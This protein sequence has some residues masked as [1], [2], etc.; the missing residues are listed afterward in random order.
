VLDG[1]HR[2]SV[3]RAWMIDDW[4]DKA[5]EFYGKNENFEDI[6]QA[7]H[8]AR[9]AVNQSIGPFKAFEEAR[10]QFDEIA[11]AGGAPMQLMSPAKAQMARFYLDTFGSNRT[12]HAQW[13]DGDYAAAEESFLVINRQ[14]VQLDDLESLLIEYRNGS[15]A[16]V[17]MSIA[18]AGAAG[19]YWPEPPVLEPLAEPLK[20]KLSTFNA[21]C[22]E[23]HRTLFVPPFDAT[24]RDINVPLIFAPGH[25]RLQQHLIELLPL[26]SE[27]A[28]VDSDGIKKLLGKDSD[29]LVQ[30]MIINADTLLSLVEDKLE[31]I[32]GRGNGSRSLALVPLIY[33][34]NRRA[35]FVRALMYGWM[36]WLLSGSAS[37]IQSRKIAL[38]SVR[39][40]LEDALTRFKDE[41][42]EIQHRAGAG[43]KSLG[44]IT[45]FIQELVTL[46]IETRDA[47]NETRE[48]R[49]ET[50]FDAKPSKISSRGGRSRSFSRISRA[51]IN[52]R[53][54]LGSPLR[55]EICGG[56]VDLKQGVQ[57]DH[58]LLYSA[59]GTSAPDN[60]RATHPFC[61]LFRDRIDKL[62]S[63]REVVELPPLLEIG[64]SERPFVQLRLFDSFPGE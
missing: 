31:H 57:Y 34:Y 30:D 33:W 22:S 51:E 49:L 41:F 43:F 8:A 19:H 3:L 55:C 35:A 64:S 42:A 6:I 24:V 10:A 46:L 52:V 12:L 17:I 27:G 54:L 21:R 2:L 18:N 1:A 29:G 15:M 9:D 13:E 40:E 60:G 28:P 37:E 56:V 4:G 48:K 62:R 39:G 58:K 53:A 50:L 11:L 16:R 47:D 20:E 45:N 44:K 59:G 7:A 32:G 25:F 5:G 61:N 38:S 23:L 63:G 36:H 26:L 14:G